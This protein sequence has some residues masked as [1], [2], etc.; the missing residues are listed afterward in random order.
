[1]RIIDAHIHTNFNKKKLA[2]IARINKISFSLKGLKEEMQKNN[3]ANVVSITDHFELETPIALKEITAQCKALSSII[4]CV[5]INPD[6]IS[7]E[8]L[9]KTE[10]AIKKGKIKA[11]KIYLG[12]YH[13][14]VNDKAYHQFYRLA[15]KYSIPVII[16]TG[17]TLSE[18]AKL[19]YT[20]PLSVDDVAVEFRGTNF[21]IAHIGNPWIE[22]AAAVVYKNPNV[23]ADLSGLIITGSPLEKRLSKRLKN[24]FYYIDDPSKLL[25]GSDWPIVS[26]KKYIRFIKKSIPAKYHKNIFYLNAKTLFRI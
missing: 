8:S 4:P 9:K 1:M 5:G 15:A 20:S 10:E 6:K 12:Y 24:A 22:D 21:I 25:Y 18:N 11:L 7:K 2:D 19:K 3:V 16:H 17:D 14:Y 13:R 23:Y 26:M